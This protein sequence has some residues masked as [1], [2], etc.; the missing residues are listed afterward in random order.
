[1]TAPDG[2]SGLALWLDAPTLTLSDGDA[3]SA[4]TD[5]STGGRTPV[6]SSPALRPTYKTSVI[7][8]LSVVRFAGTHALAYGDSISTASGFT[9]FAVVRPTVA[10][11]MYAVFN[12]VGNGYALGT[13]GGGTRREMLLRAVA[14]VV[15]GTFALSTAAV[16][17]A[18]G[19]G[20]GTTLYVNG[21]T[22]ATS[23]NGPASASG[24]L[25]IGAWE[26]GLVSRWQG[27]IGEVV[28]YDRV[29]T[30]VERAQVDRYL[31]LRWALATSAD[32][33]RS[34]T[35]GL[36]VAA[37][38]LARAAPTVPLTFGLSVDAAIQAVISASPAMTGL[39]EGGTRMTGLAASGPTITE[40]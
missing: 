25:M 2:I 38:R 5:R 10:A 31:A 39:V 33:A 19:G 13:D 4:W 22:D 26:T 40:S 35:F 30:A 17:S 6:Q 23:A 15:G 27:D 24:G 16:W 7:N 14:D 1:V 37:N 21:A 28:A 11:N 34:M 3:V 29:L 36:S 12:G 32:A 9:V 20:S 18:S 8:G